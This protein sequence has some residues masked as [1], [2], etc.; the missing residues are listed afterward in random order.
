M[1]RCMAVA[2]RPPYSSGQPIAAHRPPL[3]S[4]CQAARRCWDFS[5][6]SEESSASSSLARKGGRYSSSHARSS[7]RNASSSGASAKSTGKKLAA[8]ASPLLTSASG[9][10]TAVPTSQKGL[11]GYTV[12]FTF[13]AE[14]LALQD[15]ARRAMGEAS[16]QL[17]RLADDTDGIT[18][19]LWDRLVSLGWTGMLVPGEGAGL[20]EMC[21]I[22]EQMGRVP[23]PDRSSRR[24]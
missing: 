8:E 1:I 5:P 24:R 9:I 7:S 10:Y 18:P 4:R 11:R 22:L 13:D 2:L 19:E 21:I 15:V 16:D 14:Q 12:D 20:L 23:L 3:S 6:E 17:R